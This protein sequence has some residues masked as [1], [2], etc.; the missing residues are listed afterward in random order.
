MVSIWLVSYLMQQS[1][2]EFIPLIEFILCGAN[3]NFDSNFFLTIL[4]LSRFE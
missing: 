4:N 3:N 2:F 1:Y